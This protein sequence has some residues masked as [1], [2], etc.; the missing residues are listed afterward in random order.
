MQEDFLHYIWNFK[1]FDF[2]RAQTV[3]GQPVVII[4]SGTPNFNSGPDFFNANIKIGEQLWAG[5]V[6]IH[7]RS[8]DWYSHRHEIDSN[9]ENVVLHVVWENNIDIYRKDN[10]VIPT[11]ELK[12][13]TSEDTLKSYRELLL[14]PN[15]KWI[16]CE[17]EFVNFQN[18]E[19]ENWLERMYFE[20]LEQKS[21]AIGKLLKK[22]ENNWEEVLFWLL[23]RSFGL[24]VNG[25]A[26][27]SMAQSLDF[28]IIQKCR[29]SHLYLE[30][31]FFGQSGLLDVKNED[32]YFQELKKEYIFLKR[33]FGLSNSGVERPKY[34]RLRPENFPNIRLSQLAGLYSAVPHLFSKIMNAGKRKELQELLK[35][36][37]STYWKE[38]Y[39][40]GKDHSFR[41]K[42]L[43]ED[44]IDLLIINTI[45]PLK[46]YYLRS[47]GSYEPQQILQLIQEIK[48]EKN[49]VIDKF[50]LIR[51]NTSATALH[52]QALLHLKGAYCDKNYCLN[53]NLGAK[54]I[55]G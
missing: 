26:F 39:T 55:R 31:L 1:K 30:A 34:F 45:I 3:D 28:S 53:C 19:I 35:V 25:E 32:V 52:S 14:A 15:A 8:S 23:A 36:E 13:L 42:K 5:N 27:L 49:S 46:F 29:S 51:P 41:A 16:N 11:L 18:F 47:I 20:K 2:R 21:E 50:N 7:I 10:S 9:Y 17:R 22:S 43:S 37:T 24:K 44:F 38:H 12:D 6:E 4:N 54:L 48:T 33:K 40:F